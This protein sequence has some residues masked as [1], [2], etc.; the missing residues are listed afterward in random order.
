MEYQNIKWEREGNYGIITLNR[1]KSL[2]ALSAPL[3]EELEGLI[4]DI[5]KDDNLQAFILTGSPRPDGRPCFSAGAD[6]KLFADGDKDVARSMADHFGRAFET[7]A[8]FRGVTIAA[9]NGFAMG[10]GLE[11][12]LACD[13]R[14]VEQQAQ[15]ALPE[16]P[17]ALAAPV[18]RRTAAAPPPSPA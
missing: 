7:L 13:I 1:P 9:I 11:C 17:R 2:N 14:I 16:P 10:G 8:G 5:E 4:T 12:A 15:L 3:F 18:R 6:L